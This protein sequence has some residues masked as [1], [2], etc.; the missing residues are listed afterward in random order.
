M[1]FTEHEMTV[2]V[3]VVTRQLFE[4]A[5]APWRR[6]GSDAAWQRLAPIEKYR[7][8]SAV[9]EMLLPALMALPERPTVGARPVFDDGE[10]AEAAE[11]AHRARLEHRS[12]GAWEKMSGRRRRRL[13]R[14]TAALTRS[15]V[16][17]MPVRQDPDGL[18][19]APDH[20]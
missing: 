3:D 7:R 17:A 1:R 18:V 11:A 15:A 14:T 4:A 13:T 19:I 12:P 5:R 6:G 8:R 2:A 9:G 16:N 10:Y 20:P